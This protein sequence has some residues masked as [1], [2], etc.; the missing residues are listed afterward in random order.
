MEELRKQEE[1]EQKMGMTATTA[2]KQDD[3]YRFRNGDGRD[4]DEDTDTLDDMSSDEDADEGLLE[5]EEQISLAGDGVSGGRA[6][7]VRRSHR[8]HHAPKDEMGETAMRRKENE[9]GLQEA[10]KLTDIVLIN[11][12]IPKHLRTDDRVNLFLHSTSRM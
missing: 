5:D 9:E 2:N 3:E 1:R 8:S 11:D 4:D 7:V 6:A 12:K 10:S